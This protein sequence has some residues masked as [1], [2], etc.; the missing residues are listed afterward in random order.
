MKTFVINVLLN[1][2]LQG[3]SS[4]LP[5]GHSF[6]PEDFGSANELSKWACMFE[7]SCPTVVLRDIMLYST[8]TGKHASL[9]V[10]FMHALVLVWNH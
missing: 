2:P 7:S 1:W 5:E 3:R 6:E 10:R 4:E 8:V 9:H